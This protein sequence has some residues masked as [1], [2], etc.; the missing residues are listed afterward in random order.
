MNASTIK[1]KRCPKG[2]RRNKDTKKC[3]NIKMRSKFK[4]GYI[5]CSLILLKKIY[6]I[7]QHEFSIK[8]RGIWYSNGRDWRNFWLYDKFIVESKHSGSD[9]PSDENDFDDYFKE[10]NYRCKFIY[11]VSVEHTNFEEINKTKVLLIDT[12]KKLYELIIK[13]GKTRT[14]NNNNIQLF[15]WKKISKDFGGIEFKHIAK[16]YDDVPKCE[17]ILGAFSI[18]SGCVWN[19]NAIKITLIKK[20]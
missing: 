6:N 14:I 5:H 7:E 1:L 16:L 3:E 20:M 18:D 9:V 10:I 4:H 2:K 8:P 11:K 12:P 15:N 17:A 13:Y 19:K